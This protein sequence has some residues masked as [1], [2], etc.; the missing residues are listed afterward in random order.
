MNAD[1]LLL[2]AF[3]SSVDVEVVFENDV[4]RD[5]VAVFLSGAELYLAGGLDGLL[6]EAVGQSFDDRDVRDR[7]RR[8]QHRAES[9]ESRDVVP[10]CLF[11]ESRLRLV[12][13]DGALRH[14]VHPESSVVVATAA[15]AAV[16]AAAGVSVAAADVVASTAPQPCAFAL[17]HAAACA[18]AHA[19]ALSGA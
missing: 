3:C 19:A 10:A 11:G 1:C 14:L 9:H 13:D 7:A 16:A 8:R 12:G 2:S 15:C 18:F 5:G 6:R 17:A 4:L